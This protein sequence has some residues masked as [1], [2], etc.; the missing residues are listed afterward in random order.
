M[1]PIIERCA[2]VDIGQATVVACV[3]V[4]GPHQ[5]ARKEV[6]TFRTV[7]KELLV[8]R[9]W[10]SEK[11]V[12]HV[13]ME[14]TGVYWKPVYALL[15]DGFELIVGNAQHIKAVPGRKTDVKDSEWLADLVRHGLIPKS[16]VPPPPIRVLRDLMRYRKKLVDSRTAERNRL[17]KLLETANIKLSSVVC[18]VFGVSGMLMLRALLRGSSNP[19]VM[20]QLAKGRLRRRV[21]DLE[22]ALDGRMD[23]DHRFLL[24]LQL[25]RLKALDRHMAQLDIRIDQRLE[26]YREKHALLMQIPGV[27]RILAATLIAELGVDM[28]VFRGPRAVAAW[29]GVCPGNNES[30]GRR[31]GAKT[32]KGN[33]HLTTALVEAAAGASRKHGS[34]LRDKFFRLKA[35][36]GHN[37]AAIAI[38]HKILIAAYQ[39]LATG[40]DYKDLG[41]AYLDHLDKTKVASQ[42]VRRLNR[43]GY[44]VT[45]TENGARA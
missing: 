40:V 37:R 22:L 33:V 32:R 12:T 41:A 2:G 1:E 45:I 8:M 38:G 31:R 14:S 4:G 28:T 43:L 27:D 26:P 42:L 10:F 9:D 5:R 24:S 3:L 16:F 25:A 39:M 19:Q 29:A 11:G 34:Y 44:E 36:R 35:R 15:E 13:A 30:A 17:L 23:E 18:D 20:A 21:D 6:R 7:T